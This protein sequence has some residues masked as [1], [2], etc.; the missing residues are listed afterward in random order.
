MERGTS[1]QSH[2]GLMGHL[3]LW[4]TRGEEGAENN[5]VVPSESWHMVFYF[6]KLSCILDVLELSLGWEPHNVVT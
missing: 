3:G 4:I 5:S 1:S 6:Q 2:V